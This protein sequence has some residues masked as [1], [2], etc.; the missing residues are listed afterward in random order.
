MD[1]AVYRG[2]DVVEPEGFMQPCRYRVSYACARCGHAWKKTYKSIPADDPPCPSVRCAVARETAALALQVANLTRM[3]E[4]GRAPATI[5]DKPIVKAIDFT[6]ETVMR[7]NNVTNLKDNIRRGESM[8]P[9]L[10]PPL[11]RAADNFFAAGAKAQ[12]IGTEKPVAT[13]LQRQM[14]ALGRRAIAGAFRNASVP[15]NL[16]LPKTRPARVEVVNPGYVRR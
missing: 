8:A 7:D 9:P 14:A 15:P 3:L 2:Y 13:R 11:Q 16:V 12:A 5:G 4:E 10:A 1:D 6:A